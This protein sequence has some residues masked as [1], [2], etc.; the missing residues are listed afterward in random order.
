MFCRHA[1]VFTC[2]LVARIAGTDRGW[3]WTG[4]GFI[5]AAFVS[6]DVGRMM[7]VSSY[8]SA[9]PRSV[10]PYMYSDSE[11][12]STRGLLVVCSFLLVVEMCVVRVALRC[13]LLL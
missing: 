7:W 11:D 2:G 1:L 9:C 8:M 6:T 12:I 3:I 13:S 4:L 5:T 10:A